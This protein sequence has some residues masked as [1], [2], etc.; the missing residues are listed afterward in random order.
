MYRFNILNFSKAE[1]LYN[2]GMRP[3]L[4][5]EK[6][7][8]QR[9]VGWQHAGTDILYYRNYVTRAPGC[10]PTKFM[11]LTFSLKFEEHDDTCYLAQGYPYTYTDMLRFLDRV[12]DGKDAICKI[13]YKWASTLAGN[14]CPCMTIT[15]EFDQQGEPVHPT[16]QEVQAD[17]PN[18]SLTVQKPIKE[19]EKKQE[20]PRSEQDH[21]DCP[22]EEPE[23]ELAPPRKPYVVISARVHPGETC[24]SYMLEGLISYLT[25]KECPE[26][27]E[28]RRKFVFKIVPMLNPDGV[29][30]GNSR[31]SLA[32]VDLNR[33]YHTKAANGKNFPTILALKNMIKELQLSSQVMLYCDMHGHSRRSEV[34]M[35][36]NGEAD[37]GSEP[38]PQRLFPELYA[39]NCELFSLERSTWTSPAEKHTTSR[40]LF[41]RELKV[42]HSYTL[43]ASLAGSASKGV[44]FTVDDMISIGDSFGVTL[45]QWAR[46]QE[47]LVQ[48][49]TQGKPTELS[50]AP[51]FAAGDKKE[52][53]KKPEGLKVNKPKLDKHRRPKGKSANPKPQ[54]RT[55]Q[56]RA[57]KGNSTLAA[58]A[59]SERR[60]RSELVNSLLEKHDKSEPWTR[61]GPKVRPKQ[62]SEQAPKMS[63]SCTLPDIRSPSPTR[64]PRQRF[65]KSP[66]SDHSASPRRS[67]PAMTD[68]LRGSSAETSVSDSSQPSNQSTKPQRR[69]SQG[70]GAEPSYTFRPKRERA[71]LYP[72][73]RAEANS[74]GS[75]SNS[76]GSGDGVRR[77][78]SVPPQ[79]FPCGGEQLRPQRSQR[80]L[81][82]LPRMGLRGTYLSSDNTK[83]F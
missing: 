72:A 11:T 1:S 10:D 74:L 75:R 64:A 9:G 38:C 53:G 71:S 15:D 33:R 16:L 25:Q 36:G 69:E 21:L 30:L 17:P 47:L 73:A 8:T 4:Y 24:A 41:W 51:P 59:L 31:C 13:D 19:P 60:P 82:A 63:L 43:E 7:A 54:K 78:I 22:A 61:S 45:G 76:L 44:H 83:K 12:Q 35:F 42:E 34:F 3:L 57:L 5:S 27:A 32:G 14:K 2:E 28:L 62:S 6:V 49:A 65:A 58:G 50:G 77:A 67:P 81:V 52:T 55:Q 40:V 66:S 18:W 56:K 23:P 29:V 37:A 48:Q 68:P 39:Q 46:Q 70:S 80:D 79:V 26:A 20:P